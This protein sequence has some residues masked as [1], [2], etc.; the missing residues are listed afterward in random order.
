MIKK[1]GDFWSDK[2]IN[3]AKNKAHM[4]LKH[5]KSKF[6]VTPTENQAVTTKSEYQF[7]LYY[8]EPVIASIMKTGFTVQKGQ[9]VNLDGP[10]IL[11]PGCT[12][13]VEDGGVLSCAG[14]I[15]NRGQI[16]VQPGGTMIVQDL[17]NDTGSAA[18]GTITNPDADPDSAC[19]RIACDGKMI[20]MRDCKVCAS[21]L[22]GLEF[23]E[24]AQVVNYG[25]IIS[26]NL[27]CRTDHT[28]EN[29][30]DTSAVF[31]GWGVTDIG[32]ELTQKQITGQDYPG[33]GTLQKTAAVKLP[34]NA[35]YGE[36]ASRLYVNTARSVTYTQ[37]AS[38]KGY[39]SGFV[40]PMPVSDEDIQIPQDLPESYI[41]MRDPRYDVLF[42]EVGGVLYHYD[43]NV[44][45]WVYI[46]EDGSYQI[47]NY[48]SG[49]QLSDGDSLLPDGYILSDG[50]VVNSA[51]KL[52]P[53]GILYDV[54]ENVFWIEAEEDGDVPFYY[55]EE[56]LDR[57]VYVD[58][59][60][61]YHLA[62]EELGPPPGLGRDYI[63][64]DIYSDVPPGFRRYTAGMAES[65]GE[66]IDY[67]P[68]AKPKV[69]YD[70]DNYPY[71]YIYYDAGDG[72]GVQQYWFNQNGRV[73]M[74]IGTYGFYG[75]SVS[76]ALSAS[77]Y[78]DWYTHDFAYPIGDT[79]GEVHCSAA[80]GMVLTTPVSVTFNGE[81][82]VAV[83]KDGSEYTGG[84]GRIDAVGS[85]TV[86]ASVGGQNRRLLSF[87]LVGSSTNAIHNLVMPDGFYITEATRDGE[88]IYAD[89]YTVSMETEGEYS[90]KYECSATDMVYKL[91]TRIDRTPPAL[92][93]SGRLDKQGR[94]RSALSFGGLQAGDSIYLT[95]S[96]EYAECTLNEDG[97]GAVLDPGNYVMIVKD[98]AGN[99]VEYDFIILQYYNLQ[100]W[101][102]FLM[103]IAALFAV[104]MYVLL[105]RKRLKIA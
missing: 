87:T 95:R 98:A 33:K 58:L 43:S 9:V 55:W 49:G 60:N 1:K 72:S 57:W 69:Q 91:E 15:L 19:G 41:V 24:G 42:I 16:L 47:F 88:Y 8:A 66:T 56:T 96:G 70:P 74:L 27:S 4:Q 63:S 50:R 22:Y 51:D 82:P 104:G 68:N 59:L 75:Q 62:D 5:D 54:H 14:W 40:A 29:R 78:Y 2:A 20:V 97:T 89:R 93:F 25:Q 28:I 103:V 105:Q 76:T 94:V 86:S 92:T 85:Y 65:N 83:Y 23:G 10:I 6:S 71:Y 81:A 35:V 48:A 64:S 80:D 38:E 26:E 7:R 34:Q 67:D 11:D 101:V 12:V 73:F 90:I 18:C 39:V 77:M 100:S 79:L 30:G 102:F 37:P 44:G 21:G 36:G 84:L 52:P 3:K 31:A 99:G 45:R 13:T 53:G 46:Q 61:K 32:Y 17:E